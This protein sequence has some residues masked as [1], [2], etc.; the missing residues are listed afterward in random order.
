MPSTVNFASKEYLGQHN[1]RAEEMEQ[2]LRHIEQKVRLDPEAR[3]A[4]EGAFSSESVIKKQLVLRSEKTARKLYYVKEGMFRSFYSH[5][6]KQVTSWF[7]AKDQWMTSWHS[8][9]RQSPGFESIEALEDGLLYALD[10]H[11]YRALI[12]ESRAF[13]SFMRL[14]AEEQLAFMDSYFKGYMFMSAK[15]KYALLLSVFPDIELRV[16]L[17]YIASYLGISQE[18]LSRLRK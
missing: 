7:Y 18:T 6:G 8:F 12:K 14:L 9:Y 2:L 16:K 1:Y 13:E 4:I 5:D 15:E 11:R 10:I 3:S 17:G